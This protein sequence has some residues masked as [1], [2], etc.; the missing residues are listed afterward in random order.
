GGSDDLAHCTLVDRALGFELLL[1][2]ALSAGD[3]DAA[4]VWVTRLGELAA[5]PIPAPVVDRALSRYAHATGSV[6][7]AIV[8]VQRSLEACQEQGRAL[9]AAEANLLLARYRIEVADI[10]VASRQLRELVAASDQRGHAA[11]RRSATVALGAARRRLPPVT[12]G[13]W[14]VLSPRE[15]EVARMI[16]AGTSTDR[17]AAELFLTPA[18]IRLHTSRVLCAFAVPN[19]IGLLAAVSG[20]SPRVPAVDWQATLTQRQIEVLALLAHAHSNQQ[21]ASELGISVKAVEKH[22]AGLRERLQAPSRFELARIWWQ[23][24]DP[25]ESQSA[26]A[27]QRAPKR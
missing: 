20:Q 19:R 16:L 26:A 14:A 25:I 9:E 3:L 6:D 1:V 7:E 12:G 23:A 4:A 13:G 21:I 24:A 22:V 2:A 5:D 27:V 11:V 18:T 17:I 8:L 10:A 15:A